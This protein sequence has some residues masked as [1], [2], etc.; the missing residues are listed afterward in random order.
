MD[1]WEIKFM[2]LS[3]SLLFLSMARYLWIAGSLLK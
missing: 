3:I 1:D 2:A